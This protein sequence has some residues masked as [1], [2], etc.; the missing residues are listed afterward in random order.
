MD[1][2]RMER[3]NAL[4]V[5]AKTDRSVI[6]ELWRAVER[7]IG[8][9]CARYCRPD[10]GNHIFEFDDLCQHAFFGFVKAI[11]TY[12]RSRGAFSTNLMFHVRRS[13]CQVIGRYGSKEDPIY[14]AYSADE[15]PYEEG[16]DTYKDLIPD[17][18]AEEPFSS[19]EAEDFLAYAHSV[20]CKELERGNISDNARKFI[21]L[22]YFEGMTTTAASAVTNYN[23]YQ[24]ASNAKLDVFR[25]IRCSSAASKLRALLNDFAEFDIE[26]AGSRG[27]GVRR[28]RETWSSATERAALH[29]YDQGG[30]SR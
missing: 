9:I 22:I 6:P 18:R 7:W 13:C 11:E 12:D 21:K 20:L 15:S 2:K 27:V 24:A 8:K 23:T 3:V 10:E 5:Q 1:Y 30:I 29:L 28:F 14:S 17:D 19:F 4:A 26:S 25:K 16:G